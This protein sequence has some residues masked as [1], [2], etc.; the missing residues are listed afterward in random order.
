MNVISMM[1]LLIFPGLD[2]NDYFPATSNT[3]QKS[4]FEEQ[5]D[6]QYSIRSIQAI[7]KA[8]KHKTVTDISI[9]LELLEHNK[10]KATER[11]THVSNRIILR[12]LSPFDT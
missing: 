6:D 9:I 7:F 1:S 4:L 3:N 12:V 11:Y 10:S 5:F 2:R 8:V